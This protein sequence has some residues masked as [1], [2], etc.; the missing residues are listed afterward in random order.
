MLKT[1]DDISKLLENNPD[2]SDIF[3]AHWV[4]DIYRRP[5]KL[6]STSNV[7]GFNAP[8]VNQFFDVLMEMYEKHKF[9]P[10]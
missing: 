6:V 9:P 10:S 5:D 4:L 1:A 7:M 3:Q 8:K 2:S